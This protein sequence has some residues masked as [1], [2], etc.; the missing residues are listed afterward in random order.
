M[1]VIICKGTVLDLA[2]SVQFSSLTQS[3]S[4]LRDPMDWSKPGLPVHHQ[5]WELAQTHVHQVGDVI[6]LSV[7][8]PSPFPPS[9]FHLSQHQGLCQ[10]AVL[11]IRW[12]KYWNFSFSISPSNE[13]SGMFPLRWTG[14]ISLQF[15]GLSR[16]FSNI[17]VQKHQF[18]TVQFCV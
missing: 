5:F 9:A 10:W 8:L 16:V 6:Q 14:W 12:Q 2:S 17:T 1:T 13:C 18:F 7:P 3:W 11:R 15:K 4:T